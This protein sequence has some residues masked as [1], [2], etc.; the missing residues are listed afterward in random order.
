MLNNPIQVELPLYI[1]DQITGTVQNVKVLRVLATSIQKNTTPRQ[2]METLRIF[3]A[4]DAL[5]ER[6]GTAIARKLMDAGFRDFLQAINANTHSGATF[7]RNMLNHIQNF[8]T[9]PDLVNYFAMSLEQLIRANSTLNNLQMQQ[10][11]QWLNQL[12]GMSDNQALFQAH[13]TESAAKTTI[14]ALKIVNEN[15]SKKRFT[16]FGKN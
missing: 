9:R 6:F 4:D 12:R 10:I 14:E 13:V 16:L 8:P 2:M 3:F 1:K 11:A 5:I 7:L 15:I